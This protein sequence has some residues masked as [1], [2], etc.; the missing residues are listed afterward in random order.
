MWETWISKEPALQAG[1]NLFL[2]C[3]V[4]PEKPG[5]QKLGSPR[6]WAPQQRGSEA[7]RGEEEEAAACEHFLPR[8]DSIIICPSPPSCSGTP[9]A[10]AAS[11]ESGSTS[12]IA[13]LVLQGCK[14][15]GEGPPAACFI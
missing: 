7:S 11:A 3:A 5:V 4:P 12:D 6:S 9:A 15:L 14:V 2:K 13:G 1:Q 8:G 10:A